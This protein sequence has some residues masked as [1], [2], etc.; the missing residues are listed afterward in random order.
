MMSVLEHC[1]WQKRSAADKDIFLVYLKHCSCR[2]FA[3]KT[4]CEWTILPGI[5]VWLITT[6]SSQQLTRFA[7][8]RCHSLKW[9]CVSVQYAHYTVNV[10][11]LRM[12]WELLQH[13]AYSPDLAPSIFHLFGPQSESLGDIKFKNDKMF[14]SIVSWNSCR[15]QW[16]L[17]ATSSNRLLEQWEHCSELQGEYV[18][19]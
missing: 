14:Y 8:E 2:L 1:L 6:S 5:I 9:H 3:W 18:E 13:L 15:C 19:K 17:N 4:Y 16:K 7:A 10:R 12:D 11:K